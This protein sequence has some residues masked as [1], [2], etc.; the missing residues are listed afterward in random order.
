MKVLTIKQPWAIMLARGIKT[1]ETRSWSTS[2]R[3]EFLI[4]AA[5][6]WD[7]DAMP[8]YWANKARLNLPDPDDM[9]VGK[10]IGK[11]E[12]TAVIPP[13]Q[14]KLSLKSIGQEEYS[15]YEPNMFVFVCENHLEFPEYV[16]VS[17]PVKRNLKFWEHEQL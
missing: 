10:I 8:F 5:K 13:D 12:L 7:W 14:Y 9:P 6:G 3:G 1:D 2:F 11:A 4:H 16:A 17:A 15:N